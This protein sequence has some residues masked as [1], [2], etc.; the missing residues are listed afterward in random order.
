MSKNKV[1]CR[2]TEC[3]FH[4]VTNDWCAAYNFGGREMKQLQNNFTT[5][6]QSKRLL[7]LGVPVD[8]ADCMNYTSPTCNGDIVNTCDAIQIPYGNKYSEFM[9]ENT[10]PIWSVGRMIE[11]WNICVNLIPGMDLEF[12]THANYTEDLVRDFEYAKQDGLIDF[13]KLED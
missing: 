6:E 11:I 4:G 9:C 5:V 12:P 8:S 3:R 2:L 1:E 10:Y 13:S 7:E